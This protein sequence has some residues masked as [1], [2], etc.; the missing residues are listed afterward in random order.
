M[1]S[2]PEMDG[3]GDTG[4]DVDMV[5]H[6]D[7]PPLLGRFTAKPWIWALG[8]AVVTSAVWAG[9]LRGTGFG[10]TAA[11][12]LHG[13][14]LDESPSPCTNLRMQPLAGDLGATSFGQTTPQ[15]T[16]SA[17]LDR[18]SCE[19]IGSVTRDD[20][21]MTTY[22]MAVTVD[23]HKKTDPSTEFEAL[24]TSQVSSPTGNGSGVVVSFVDDHAMTTHPQGLG[25]EAKLITGDYQQSLYVRHG[26]AVFSLTLR[27]IKEWDTGSGKPPIDPAGNA[28]LPVVADTAAFRKD[29]APTVRTVMRAMAQQPSAS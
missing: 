21:W 12:D 17:A 4:Q 10:H 13:Y 27:G 19:L 22:T 15:I 20:G 26:G 1:I 18:V 29:L 2:E 7:R 28:P 23:L 24:S 8:A 9:V 3:T 14:H 16:R 6:T 5:S 11:P 25:D